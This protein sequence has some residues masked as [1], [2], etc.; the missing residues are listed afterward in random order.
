MKEARL[1]TGVERREFASQEQMAD[2]VAALLGRPLN[3]TQW[4]RYEQGAEPPLDVIQA[5]AQLSGLT[6]AYIAFGDVQAARPRTQ[7]ELEQSVS[8]PVRP[9]DDLRDRPKP[10]AKK[11]ASGGRRPK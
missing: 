9:P 4:S 7:Q 8:T 11:R 3:Q 2:L 6:P 1:R 5:A 10:P